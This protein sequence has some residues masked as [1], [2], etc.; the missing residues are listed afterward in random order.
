MS[1]AK[2]MAFVSEILRPPFA[3]SGYSFEIIFRL[4]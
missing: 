2:D 4:L 3:E 1:E